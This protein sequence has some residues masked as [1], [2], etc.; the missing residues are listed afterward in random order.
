MGRPDLSSLTRYRALPATRPQT[1]AMGSI[2]SLAVAKTSIRPVP[3]TLDSQARTPPT[4]RTPP[5]YDLARWLAPS[6]PSPPISIG[7]SLA[8]ALPLLSLPV[9]VTSTWRLTTATTPT[10]TVRVVP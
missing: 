3:G 9:V 1:V 4:R 6:N 2:T 7:L 5:P 8:T 10:G